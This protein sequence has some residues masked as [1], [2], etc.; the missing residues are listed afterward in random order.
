MTSAITLAHLTGPQSA[1]TTA[2]AGAGRHAITALPAPDLADSSQISWHVGDA[3]TITLLID[4]PGPG[5]RLD[6]HLASDDLESADSAAA[7]PTALR[8]A[9]TALLAAAATIDELAI[10]RK[11]PNLTGRRDHLLDL[12]NLLADD[13]E[14]ATV[15]Q[16]RELATAAKAMLAGTTKGR[17]R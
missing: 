10:A 8:A 14:T 3:S 11:F 7:D 4:L 9:G 2:G 5:P 12:A 6:I 17:S 13:P 15:D 16:I 1:E